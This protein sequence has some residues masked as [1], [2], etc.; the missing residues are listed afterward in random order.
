MLRALALALSLN[1]GQESDGGP[2]RWHEVAR[3]CPTDCEPCSARIERALAVLEQATKDAID[4]PAN[5]VPLCALSFYGL[6]F[7][8]AGFPEGE[9][10]RR[11]AFERA[12]D[13]V[14]SSLRELDLEAAEA[15]WAVVLGTL[16]LTE[17]QLAAPSP[18]HQEQLVALCDRLWAGR[19]ES[20]DWAVHGYGDI[21]SH[22]FLAY[23][24]LGRLSRCGVALPEGV[25]EGFLEYLRQVTYPS[26]PI[27]YA[28]SNMREQ[29]RM[30]VLSSHN[31][32]TAARNASAVLAMLE[33]GLTENELY[34]PILGYLEGHSHEAIHG[35]ASPQFARL[36]G[37]L[38][39]YRLGP[40]AW[41]RFCDHT[42]SLEGVPERPRDRRSVREYDEEKR[43]EALAK[44]GRT[45]SLAALPIAD[46]VFRS[47]HFEEA[48][49]AI[50]LTA[51]LERL[52][53]LRR[54]DDAGD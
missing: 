28:R 10:D 40:S 23:F 30:G 44:Y 11:A 43:R 15:W 38:A 37:G 32:E 34:P 50:L 48:V 18:T 9:Q 46:Q 49:D 54:S 31:V 26:G 21:A 16:F 14:G 1:G 17:A 5:P 27:E 41:R 39:H 51:P 29:R 7:L 35:H 12:R 4:G 33:L 42:L 25:R 24:V 53:L 47:I 52:H 20:A 13:R 3:G 2:S 6:A 19:R 8:G 22:T 36:I 45:V